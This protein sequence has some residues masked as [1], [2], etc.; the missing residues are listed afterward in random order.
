MDH[1]HGEVKAQQSQSWFQGVQQYFSEVDF[2]PHG[3]CYLWKPGLVST[4][5]IS[6]FLIGLAYISISVTLYELVKKTNLKFNTVVLCFGVFIGACGLTHFN[7]IWNLWYSDYWYSGAVK[8]LTAAAS[9][10]TGIY[11]V[12]L[13]HPILAV[14]QAAK[15]SEERRLDLEALTKDLEQ[16]VEERTKEIAEKEQVLRMAQEV[17]QVGTFNWYIPTNENKWTPELE[18]LYGIPE[19]TFKGTYEE[20]KKLVHPDDLD[21]AESAL[22]TAFDEGSFKS[23]W[24]VIWPDGSIHWLGARGQVHKD[25]SG[26]PERLIGINIDITKEKETLLRL[27]NAVK[28]RDEFLSLASHELKT[29]LTSLSLQ[30]QTMKR[31]ISKGDPVAYSKPRVDILLEQNEKHVQR[32]A[33]LVD[34]MLDIGRMRTGK[35]TMET[36][37]F[38]IC[39]LVSE[40]TE[41]IRPQFNAA[42]TSLTVKHCESTI[43]RWDRFRI[44]QVFN[45]LLTNALKYGS[46]KPVDL[47]V[48]S[49]K[50]K[51][52]VRIVDHGIGISKENQIRIFDRFERAISANE[53][54]GLG[55]GL[56]IA[57][58]IILSHQGYIGVESEPGEGSTFFFELPIESE[59]S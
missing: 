37:E 20:W 9:V 39:E 31:A 45:N 18:K 17:A 52:V 54:S 7:E 59:G 4:H 3:H 57:K 13:R 16:R 36:E 43:G 22:K 40:V 25:A 29:P 26:K 47:E 14:A 24:R 50:D 27:N 23:E 2:M 33:R 38:D 10:G 15:L 34:D 21:I 49:T 55:L 11:L 41:R 8:V 5:V 42:G 56:F 19:G 1:V 6:D 30:T 35:L 48:Y 58:E 28:S 51:V 32:L 44:E 53:V 12:K 46:H